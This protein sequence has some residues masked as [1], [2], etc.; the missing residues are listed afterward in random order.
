VKGSYRNNILVAK[1][2]IEATAIRLEPEGR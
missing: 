1:D 2:S